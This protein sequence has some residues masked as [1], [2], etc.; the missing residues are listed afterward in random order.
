MPANSKVL[1]V[2]LV[3]AGGFQACV[4][5]G[6]PVYVCSL[7]SADGLE[8]VLVVVLQCPLAALGSGAWLL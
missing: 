2:L 1:L 4:A 3:D 6:K 8:D 7:P 5:L